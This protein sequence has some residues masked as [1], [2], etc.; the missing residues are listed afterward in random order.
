MP[1][2]ITQVDTLTDIAIK[3]YKQH[4]SYLW[5]DS[6][7]AYIGRVYGKDNLLADLAKPGAHYFFVY[8]DSEL[9][10]YFRIKKKAYPGNPQQ[11]GLEISKLYLL[12]QAIG[13]G[14]G[15]KIMAF[16][17]DWA[18]SHQ[19][20]IVWLMV[21]ES[22]PAKTFYESFGFKHT[23][24]SYLDYQNMVDEYRWILTMAVGDSK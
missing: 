21:M 13:K 24:R 5:L 2:D 9:L 8:D 4:Y 14:I 19:C 20:T 18:K 10:G 17:F 7:N 1:C 22:S 16:I 23:G 6:G 11:S 15:G 12:Q 3:T